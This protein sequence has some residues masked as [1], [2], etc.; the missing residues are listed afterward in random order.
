[1]MRYRFINAEKADNNASRLCGLFKV[2]RAGFYA[3]QNWPA[4]LRSREDN[5][6][7]AHIRSEFESS[8]R[9]YGRPRMVEELREA[10][11]RAAIIVLV[12]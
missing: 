10:G 3:W 7:L 2:S 6:L 9:P 8:H 12:G 11:F 4:S 1:M 5:I